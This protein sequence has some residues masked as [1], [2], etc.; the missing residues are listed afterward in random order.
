MKNANL[1]ESEDKVRI[2]MV[3]IFYS[4]SKL[5]HNPRYKVKKGR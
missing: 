2:S 3:Q 4:N 5:K 1:K